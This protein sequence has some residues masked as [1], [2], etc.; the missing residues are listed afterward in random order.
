MTLDPLGPVKSK[1]G[2]LSTDKRAFIPT[3]WRGI[4]GNVVVDVNV[5]VVVVVV[6]VTNLSNNTWTNKRNLKNLKKHFGK[7]FFLYFKL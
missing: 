3:N 2:H 6:V 4:I 7:C 1:E 5:V